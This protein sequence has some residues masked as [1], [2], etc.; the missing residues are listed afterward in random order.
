M[1]NTV[2][3]FH[4]L[5]TTGVFN[6]AAEIFQLVENTY[7]RRTTYE[8]DLSSLN[9]RIKLLEVFD[10]YSCMIDPET[11]NLVFTIPDE[12]TVELA[13]NSS[14]DLILTSYGTVID[15]ALECYSFEIRSDGM[16][17]LEIDIS[18]S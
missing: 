1:P 17:Y 16:L 14:G 2:D 9:E 8:T 6:A 10:I 13:I 11:G 7:V 18:Q 12:D 5:D 4:A 3:K 15:N